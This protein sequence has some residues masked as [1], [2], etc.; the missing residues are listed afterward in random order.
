MTSTIVR[1]GLISL[2]FV[3]A[4]A[5]TGPSSQATTVIKVSFS[6]TGFSGYIEYDPTLAGTNGDFTF[7]GSTLT[8][9]IC[10]VIGSGSCTLYTQKQCEP[11]TITTSGN[12]KYL[13]QLNV[14]APTNPS[15]P[16]VVKLATN[17]ALSQTSLPSCD[18]TTS[19]P[20]AVFQASPAAGASTFAVTTNGVTTTY[21]IISVSCTTVTLTKTTTLPPSPQCPTCYT[22]YE[23]PVPVPSPV[24]AC[25]TRR[26]CFLSRLLHRGSSRM[27]CR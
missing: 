6:G 3:L 16:V 23:C 22:V 9:Q 18:T 24:Y 26:I 25:Q 13:F 20:T 2:V 10:Y 7:K 19:P 4:I 27:V 12:N 21:N 17:V 11:Y 1:P 15:T 8:H 5:A 14:T